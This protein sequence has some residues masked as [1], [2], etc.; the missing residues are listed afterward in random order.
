MDT[1]LISLHYFSK[2]MNSSPLSLHYFSKLTDSSLLSL[3][4][5]SKLMDSSLL[6]LHYFYK[7]TDTSLISL[8][9]FSKLMDTFP[10][11]L[12][13]KEGKIIK[14][15]FLG[16]F[17]LVQ[18]QRG[19]FCILYNRGEKFEKKESRS[20]EHTSELQSRFDLVCRLLLEK[21]NIITYSS[22]AKKRS[23]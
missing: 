11:L 16:I 1:S 17:L 20:E 15:I 19:L 13:K 21:K 23:S 12:I 7:L 6:F 18:K 2:L 9:S 10:N 5:F 14:K 22:D 3:H 4:Y 8:H